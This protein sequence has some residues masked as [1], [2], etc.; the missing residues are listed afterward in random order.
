MEWFREA[1]DLF[2]TALAAHNSES[3]AEPSAGEMYRLYT[4][5]HAT[6]LADW[7][8]AGANDVQRLGR[9]LRFERLWLA[10]EGQE[11]FTDPERNGIFVSA[12]VE[13]EDRDAAL[14][15]YRSLHPDSPSLESMCALG[16]PGS[17]A[18]ALM[19]A[20]S[21]PDGDTRASVYGSY[22]RFLSTVI[23]YDRNGARWPFSKFDFIRFQY[24]RHKYI[25]R[26]SPSVLQLI[27]E[28]RG[29]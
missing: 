10:L 29:V 25:E 7:A 26:H 1:L 6:Y 14:Q 28:A 9:A 2:D 17:M 22:E 21:E 23:R 16:T 19:L 11:R 8:A 4:V 20:E 3:A 13:A 15:A 27:R 24:L 12:L 5:S 18:C